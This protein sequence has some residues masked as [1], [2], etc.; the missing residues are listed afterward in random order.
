MT[1]WQRRVI[2]EQ[3]ELKGRI[4]KLSHFLD[5]NQDLPNTTRELLMAQYHAMRTYAAI[6]SM[7]I[8]QFTK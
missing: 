7:R 1:D 3:T 2:D 4:L 6:L 8:H 5:T